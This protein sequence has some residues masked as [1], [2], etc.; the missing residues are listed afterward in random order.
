MCE[1]GRVLHHLRN[2]IEDPRVVILIVGFQAEETLGRRLAEGRPTVR[3][4]GEEFSRRAEVVVMEGF[5]AHA[6]RAE[7]LAWAER[8]HDRPRK[9]FVVHG[10]LEQGEALAATLRDRGFG[11]VELPELGQEAVL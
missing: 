7:L 4:F 5:S 11:T 3:I 10:A 9:T 1:A 6:D 8:I 2:N